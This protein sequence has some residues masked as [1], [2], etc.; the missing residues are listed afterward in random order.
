MNN[1]IWKNYIYTY[2]SQNN[3]LDF[4]TRFL[5]TF[6]TKWDKFIVGYDFEDLCQINNGN[7]LR[8]M[9]VFWGYLLTK[10]DDFMFDVSDEDL[11]LIMDP[12][13]MIEAIHKM[14]LLIDDW[15]DDDIARHGTA[16]FHVV[17]GADTAV[18]F[19]M[20]ILLKGF[21]ELSSLQDEKYIKVIPL[22]LRI[23]YEMTLGAL[24]EVSSKDT[25]FDIDSVKEIIKLE[26]S[27]IIRNGMIIGYTAG[28]GNND[29]IIDLL[30]DIGGC[31]GYIFQALNDLEPFGNADE[32]IQHKGALTTDIIKNRKNVVVTYIY[33]Q[34]SE[35][36]TEKLSTL[37][38]SEQMSDYVTFLIEKYHIKEHLMEETSS[39]QERI[40]DRIAEIERV[41]GHHNWCTHFNN[42]VDITIAA[43]KKRASCQ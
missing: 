2:V 1:N 15:I 25:A 42:F 21:L 27:S 9:L 29:R 12:C 20:N 34:A 35:F 22:A 16:T 24:N 31:C 39:L 14:S 36:E 10:D 11:D 40:K 17:H 8:P 19:A 6:E 37:N 3:L 7:R 30:D 13:V 33:A 26:T 23:A 38:D 32:L 28:N 4:Y 18:L 43:S 5:D 41:T